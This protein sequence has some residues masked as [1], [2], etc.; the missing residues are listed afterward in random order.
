MT[1][2]RIIIVIPL[3]A[4]V[5]SHDIVQAQQASPHVVSAEEVRTEVATKSTW[6]EQNIKEIQKVLSHHLVQK[7]M[8]RL[9]D[10]ERVGRALPTLDDDTLSKLVSESQKIKDQLQ[11][12]TN[13]VVFV[14]LGIAVFLAVILTCCPD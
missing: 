4:F 7:H 14:A 9:V 13:P 12:G 10:L 5:C 6:R 3:V 11:A 1:V 8:G 2:L